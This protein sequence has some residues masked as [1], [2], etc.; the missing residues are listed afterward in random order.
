[1]HFVVGNNR[2][3]LLKL[4]FNDERCKLLMTLTT[5][6]NLYMVRFIEPNEINE[7]K[8]MLMPHQKAKTIYGNF[9]QY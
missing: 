4:L 2:T 5:L 3:Q 6:K 8:T 9:F 1:M 7:I